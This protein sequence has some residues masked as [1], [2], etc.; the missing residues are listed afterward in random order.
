MNVRLSREKTDLVAGSRSTARFGLRSAFS[1]TTLAGSAFGA[2]AARAGADDFVA[3]AYRTGD[4]HE[5]AAKCDHDPL[6]M[7]IAIPA[8]SRSA[9][10]VR[11]HVDHFFVGRAGQISDRPVYR[12]F[13]DLDNFLER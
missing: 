10:I 12:F 8:V 3:P 1:A 4:S 7:S 9:G 13:L 6:G 5:D 11:D 2:N